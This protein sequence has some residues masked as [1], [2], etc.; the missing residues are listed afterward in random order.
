MFF[1][2]HGDSEAL[3]KYLKEKSSINIREFEYKK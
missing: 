2:H 3:N 1:F